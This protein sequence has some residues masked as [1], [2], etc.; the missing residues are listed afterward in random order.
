MK[1]NKL[2]I[3]M[4]CSRCGR[5]AETILNYE[6]M[7]ES[8]DQRAPDHAKEILLGCKDC[9]THIRVF[10]PEDLI[11]VGSNLMTDEIDGIQTSIIMC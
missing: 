7:R 4:K 2:F 8:H 1:P 3:E 9:Q 6:D 10:L 11:K 5:T